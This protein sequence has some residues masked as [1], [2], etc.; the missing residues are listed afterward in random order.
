MDIKGCDNNSNWNYG[1]KPR[2]NRH[3]TYWS[4]YINNTAVNDNNE[5]ETKVSEYDDRRH[6]LTCTVIWNNS[7]VYK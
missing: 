4:E 2:E 6:D 3:D 5:N 1:R 7:N